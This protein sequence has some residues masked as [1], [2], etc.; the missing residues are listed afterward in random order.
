MLQMVP[1]G[2]FVIVRFQMTQ[3]T[4]RMRKFIGKIEEVQNGKFLGNFLRP[5]VTKQNAGYVFKYPVK[6]DKASFSGIQIEK[7]L[8]SPAST[9]WSVWTSPV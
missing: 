2:S 9:F 5:A 4:N 7:V 6:P 1:V 3:Q 8:P